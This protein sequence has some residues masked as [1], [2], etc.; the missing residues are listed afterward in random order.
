MEPLNNGNTWDTAFCP[1]LRGGPLLKVILY[2]VHIK[3]LFVEKFVLF[4][5]CPLLKVPLYSSQVEA[6]YHIPP[7]NVRH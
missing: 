6:I 1:V 2:K 3:V 7:I 5:E 4:S